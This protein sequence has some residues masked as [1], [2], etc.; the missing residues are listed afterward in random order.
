MRS[1]EFSDGPWPR[2]MLLT[3]E[4]NPRPL[5]ELL[6]AREAWSLAVRSDVP[7]T[8]PRVIARMSPPQGLAHGAEHWQNAW[9]VAVSFVAQADDRRRRLQAVMVDG[10]LTDA[11]ALAE[12]VPP[13]WEPL[14][15]LDSDSVRRWEESLPTYGERALHELPER[16]SVSVVA[17]AWRRGLTTIAVIPVAG[18]Y[19]ARIGRE[20]LMVS[21]GTYL[22][23]AAFEE[24]V[25]AFGS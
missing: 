8:D 25:R 24:S 13:V 15:R 18:H 14:Q 4:M 16:L 6:F 5:T 22:D 10:D 3:L 17:D 1:N 23:R 21:H 19:S 11:A 20:S 2:D 7:P 12:F 9:D